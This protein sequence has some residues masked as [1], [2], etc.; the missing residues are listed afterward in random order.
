LGEERIS[1]SSSLCRFIH[2]LVD[3]SH[4]LF[5]LRKTFASGRRKLKDSWLNLMRNPLTKA[6]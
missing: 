6:F 2:S 1:L 5:G 4:V 3:S